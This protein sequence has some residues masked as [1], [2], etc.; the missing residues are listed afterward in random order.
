MPD[1]R[2]VAGYP[3]NM[4]EFLSSNP[5]LKSRFNI[6]LTFKDFT[7]DEMLE[8][9]LMLLKK[10]N[11]TPDKKTENKLLDYFKTLYSNKDKFFGNAR[12]V[13]QIIKEAV[14]NQN[15]RMASIPADKRLKK[16]L[17]ILTIEDIQELDTIKNFM[18]NKKSIGFQ[19]N[20]YLVP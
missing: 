5:G 3:D 9:A 6:S 2:K 8:I 17:K 16:M 13:R 4:K 18:K 19:A 11:M 12:A 14:K 7:P 10:E 20:P 1:N 15:L